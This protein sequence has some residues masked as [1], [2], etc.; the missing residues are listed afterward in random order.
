MVDLPI[1]L[2]T[3]LRLMAIHEDVI[4]LRVNGALMQ[5]HKVR[6]LDAINRAEVV[7]KRVDIKI[8]T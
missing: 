5:M 3:I 8:A 1:L 7:G 6:K 4:M 2:M